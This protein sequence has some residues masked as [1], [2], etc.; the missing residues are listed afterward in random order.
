MI[1]LFFHFDLKS[2]NNLQIEKK[3][4]VIVNAKNKVVKSETTW[5]TGAKSSTHIVTNKKL[6]NYASLKK[7]QLELR[8]LKQNLRQKAYKNY[9]E[10]NDD[11]VEEEYDEDSY[12]NTTLVKA[13]DGEGEDDEVAKKELRLSRSSTSK[14]T[15]GVQ[16]PM[17]TKTSSNKRPYEQ[18]KSFIVNKLNFNL[19]KKTQMTQQQTTERHAKKVKIEKEDESADDNESD[20]EI[21]HS[22][23]EIKAPLKKPNQ[24]PVSVAF[25][26]L[27]T[28]NLLTRNVMQHPDSTAKDLLSCGT[29]KVKIQRRRS[30]VLLSSSSLNNQS[31][32]QKENDSLNGMNAAYISS[33]ENSGIYIFFFEDLP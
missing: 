21:E 26:S 12:A 30:S 5:K 1:S 28:N 4:P 20:N 19:R 8:H 13:D 25:T 24:P 29:Y 10:E 16:D 2:T 31:F 14:L 6:R 23:E 3:E 22:T 32:K 7:K 33:G 17:L 27:T 18:P 9:S 15:N 11:L